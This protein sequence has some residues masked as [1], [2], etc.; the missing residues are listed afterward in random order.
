MSPIIANQKKSLFFPIT[1]GVIVLLMVVVI[2]VSILSNKSE[3]SAQSKQEF[4]ESVSVVAASIDGNLGLDKLSEFQDSNNDPDIGKVVPTITGQNFAGESITVTPGEK[5]YALVFLA[6]WCPHCQKEVPKLVQ[7][8]N[9]NQI[10]EGVEIYGVATG[11]SS[12][13]TNFPPSKWLRS[14]S[15]P[16]KTIADN[17]SFQIAQAFGLQGY[18]YVV[19]VNADGTLY[20]RTSGEKSESEISANL[21]AILN[22][23]K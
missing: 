5:P 12:D 17:E 19:Y 16:F 8:N 6:H 18:P 7:M 21:N 23:S 9:D 11:T 3:E 13:A 15:W 4:S 22:S 20:R 14:E 1:V 2:A 10:P